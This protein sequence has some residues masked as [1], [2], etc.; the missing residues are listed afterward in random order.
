[1]L[2]KAISWQNLGTIK[3]GDAV[4]ASRGDN[5]RVSIHQTKTLTGQYALKGG[6]IGLLAGLLLGGPVVSLV[7]EPREVLLLESAKIS[8]STII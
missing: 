4:V 3:L 8:A 2:D 6:G 1:M 5:G 7:V